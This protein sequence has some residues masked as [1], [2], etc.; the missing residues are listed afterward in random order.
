MTFTALCDIPGQSNLL[1]IFLPLENFFSLSSIYLSIYLSM[2]GP[3]KRE[4]HYVD[5]FQQTFTEHG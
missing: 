4:T 3:L 5:G 1:N 2:G